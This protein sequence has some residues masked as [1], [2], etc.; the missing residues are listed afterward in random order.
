MN[1]ASR[2]KGKCATIKKISVIPHAMQRTCAAPLM[3]DDGGL[4]YGEL[5]SWHEAS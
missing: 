4:L 3:R 5:F 1:G 2:R